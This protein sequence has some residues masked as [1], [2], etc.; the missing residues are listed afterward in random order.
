MFD[1]TNSIYQSKVLLRAVD[2]AN[3]D[4]TTLAQNGEIVE[5]AAISQIYWSTDGTW[6]VRFGE[7][8]ILVLTGSGNWDLSG[9]HLGVDLQSNSVL[10]AT[11]SEGSS[12]VVMIE[13]K[14]NS[15]ISEY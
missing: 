6:T 3:V 9:L 15:F 7:N 5:K 1:V 2:T 10:T 11:K 4:I 8:E 14:K 13:V 12:G